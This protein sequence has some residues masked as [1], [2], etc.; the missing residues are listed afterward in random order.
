MSRRRAAGRAASAALVAALVTGLTG[1]G[2]DDTDDT[3]GSD[4]AAPTPPATTLTARDR[5]LSVALPG[6]WSE[7]AAGEAGKVVVAA[8]GPQGERLRVSVYDEPAGAEQAAITE[9]ELLNRRHVI[10][11]RLDD[12][13]VL[14]DPHLVFD[15]GKDDTLRRLVYVVLVDDARSALV[16]VELDASSLEQAADVVGPAVDGVSWS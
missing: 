14:G 6:G 11:E 10:C 8:S 16:G 3:D 13:D 9:T 1:C 12:S 7:E 4:S 5:A 15:C 2:G